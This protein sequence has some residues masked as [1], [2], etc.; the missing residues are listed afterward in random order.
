M[1]TKGS[2]LSHRRA[3]VK[4]FLNYCSQ[5]SGLCCKQG[6]FSAFEHE[7]NRLPIRGKKLEVS[8]FSGERGGTKDLLINGKCIFLGRKGCKL[9]VRMRT[10]DCITFPFYPV[11][12]KKTGHLELKSLL[13][14]RDCPYSSE[15]SKEEKLH[16][17]IRDYWAEIIRSIPQEELT[18][19]LG[20]DRY[21]EK[22]YKKTINIEFQ[23]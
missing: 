3:I 6:V 20:E 9:P 10:T 2:A 18:D 16:K 11:V 13:I 21:W 4:A 23:P 15:L 1:P 14:H 12:A 8:S 5:C 22:W 7:L 19:W 17:H